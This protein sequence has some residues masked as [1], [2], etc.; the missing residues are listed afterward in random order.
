LIG[1]ENRQGQ[2][3]I[4]R[5]IAEWIAWGFDKTK[6]PDCQPANGQ[7]AQKNGY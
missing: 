6:K 4:Q 2:T 1:K 5:E 3:G 7:I